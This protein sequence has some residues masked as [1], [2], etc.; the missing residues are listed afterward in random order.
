MNHIYKIKKK[1][2][3]KITERKTDIYEGQ[4][5]SGDFE[6]RF[7]WFMNFAG[8]IFVGFGAKE[9]RKRAERALPIDKKINHILSDRV[10]YRAWV[11]NWYAVKGNKCKIIR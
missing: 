10:F 11:I 6:I 1:A 8:N 4:R 7:V 2:R 5:Q 9:L 3:Q